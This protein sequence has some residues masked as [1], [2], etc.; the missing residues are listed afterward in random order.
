MVEITECNQTSSERVGPEP[1]LVGSTFERCLHP[2]IWCGRCFD[3]FFKA[4]NQKAG[5]LV[6]KRRTFLM[7]DEELIGL[8]YIW[9][10][11]LGKGF[12]RP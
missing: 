1:I 11:S 5:K 12:R 4:V 9:R 8:D 3:K 7:E 10:V 2:S 6:P